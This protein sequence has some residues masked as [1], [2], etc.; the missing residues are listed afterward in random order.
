MHYKYILV[1]M[2]LQYDGICL[3]PGDK[4]Y[5]KLYVSVL[6]VVDQHQVNYDV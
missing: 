4:E 2:T 5:I 3:E 6:L 1:L